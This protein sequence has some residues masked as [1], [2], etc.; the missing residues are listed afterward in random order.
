MHKGI[1][2]GKN[3]I[4]TVKDGRKWGENRKRARVYTDLDGG[5]DGVAN[6]AGV[7]LPGAEPH[8]GDLGAGVEHEVPRHRRL[9]LRLSVTRTGQQHRKWGT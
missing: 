9:S 4:W 2:K 7:R 6:D 1:I 5:V 3:V 8:G